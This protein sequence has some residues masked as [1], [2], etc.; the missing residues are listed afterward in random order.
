MNNAGSDTRDPKARPRSFITMRRINIFIVMAFLVTALS[1]CGGCN[2]C[3]GCTA[4][5]NQV[6][7]RLGGIL[8]SQC[9][10][11]CDVKVQFFDEATGQNLTEVHNSSFLDFDIINN[12]QTQSFFNAPI[13]ADGT[14]TVP[15]NPCFD[16]CKGDKL[17]AKVAIFGA[18]LKS[19]DGCPAGQCRQWTISS[20]ANFVPSGVQGCTVIIRV[21]VTKRSGPCRPC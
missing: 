21:P 3:S 4:A 1:G 15:L 16:F 9:T 17:D 5:L 2:G 7:C 18:S 10:K 11:F 8:S 12:G 13:A 19:R 20:A 6:F 14:L